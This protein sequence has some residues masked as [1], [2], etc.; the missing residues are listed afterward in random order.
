MGSIMKNEI[1]TTKPL[2]VAI[3]GGGFAGL[4]LTIGLLPHSQHIKTTVYESA[5]AFAEIGVG[6]AF[7]PN[8]LRAMGMISPAILKGFQKHVTGS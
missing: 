2:D 5:P 3:I 1:P 6:V 7:G 4:A 8:V